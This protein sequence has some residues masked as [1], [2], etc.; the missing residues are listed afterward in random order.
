MVY[1]TSKEVIGVNIE[2]PPEIPLQE[3][4]GSILPGWKVLKQN[5]SHVSISTED[6]QKLISMFRYQSRTEA[7]CL[8]EHGKNLQNLKEL[9]DAV[10]KVAKL[11]EKCDVAEAKLQNV[12]IINN[13]IYSTLPTRI[14]N[15]G[16]SEVLD[17][18]KTGA[19]KSAIIV[20]DDGITYGLHP[21]ESLFTASYV[22]PLVEVPDKYP[23]VLKR[24]DFS[25]P[26]EP[27]KKATYIS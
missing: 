5:N 13:L 7:A 27:T 23:E 21:S 2:I 8:S 12:P 17:M 25:M 20:A 15:K 19:L 3:R 1:E 22:C 26:Q 18:L 6:Q 14:N 9:N 4:I 10:F 24:F 16:V 11:A